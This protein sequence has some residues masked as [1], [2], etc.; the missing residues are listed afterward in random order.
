MCLLPGPAS[1]PSLLGI[2]LRFREHSVAISGDIHGMFH[3]VLL[4][5]EDKPLLRFL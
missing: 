4:L 1:R 2:L 5:P 3:Q